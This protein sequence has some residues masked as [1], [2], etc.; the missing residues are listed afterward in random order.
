MLQ[1]NALATNWG[2]TIFQSANEMVQNAII[3]EKV[4][5]IQEKGRADREWWDK[6]RAS[7]QSK[8]MQELDEEKPVEQPKGAASGGVNSDE[9]AVFVEGG[10]PASGSAPGSRGG[11]K[12]KKGKK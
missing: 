7:I 1:A 11:T 5:E 3:R 2:Q 12:K 4:A 8:F 6:E 10:G 9:D